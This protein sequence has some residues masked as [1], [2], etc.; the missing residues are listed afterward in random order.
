MRRALIIVDML[1][2]FVRPGAPLFVPGALEIIPAIQAELARARAAGELVVYVCDAHDPD[3][4]EFARFPPH[5]VAG[6]PGAQIVEELAPRPGE[7][8]LSKRRLDP[9][10]DTEL[11][12][13]LTRE[14]VE[15]ATVVGVCTHICVMETVAGL[16]SR[17]IP[18]RVP[19]AAVAD[20]D[21][22]QAQAALQRMRRVFGAQI[23]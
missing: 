1:N 13:V 7:V 16:S 10:F 15:E 14:E 3:D 9:F 2:D 8:V 6:S 21:P 12:Q 5:A 4:K 11:D 20:F 22:D 17:D 19:R 18:A 23:I